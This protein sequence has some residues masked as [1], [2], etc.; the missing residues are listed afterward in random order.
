MAMG[1]LALTLTVTPKDAQ[2]SIVK[3]VTGRPCSPLVLQA[4]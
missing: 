3:D 1:V 4:R 2:G